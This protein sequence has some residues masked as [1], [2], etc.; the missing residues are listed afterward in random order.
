MVSEILFAKIRM[1]AAQKYTN[2]VGWPMFLLAFGSAVFSHF[3]SRASLGALKFLAC[4][5]WIRLIRNSLV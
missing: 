5:A 2:F 1:N 3:A 4:D